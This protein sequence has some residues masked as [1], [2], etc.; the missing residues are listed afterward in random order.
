MKS[1]PTRNLMLSLVAVVLISLVPSVEAACTLSKCMEC[2]M[3]DGTEICQKC[4][5]GYFRD[6]AEAPQQCIQFGTGPVPLESEVGKGIDAERNLI[7][8]CATTGCTDCRA[9]FNVCEACDST[10]HYFRILEGASTCVALEADPESEEEIYPV[11]PDG[12]VCFSYSAN[13]DQILIY[14]FKRMRKLENLKMSFVPYLGDG[15]VC[16]TCDTMPFKIEATSEAG[17]E[18]AATLPFQASFAF[19][20]LAIKSFYED[21]PAVPGQSPVFDKEKVY[22]AE[23]EDTFYKTHT[24]EV[25]SWWLKIW[26]FVTMTALVLVFPM[27]S[28][29]INQFFSFIGY[30]R[31]LDG[32]KSTPTAITIYYLSSNFIFPFWITNPYLSSTADPGCVP[33]VNYTNNGLGCNIAYNF[34]QNFNIMLAAFALNLCVHIYFAVQRGTFY[35]LTEDADKDTNWFLIRIRQYCGLRYFYQFMDAYN[36][37]LLGLAFLNLWQ[38]NGKGS[39][40]GAFIFCVLLLSYYGLFYCFVFAFIRR[41]KKEIAARTKRKVRNAIEYMDE[42]D[43]VYSSDLAFLL[44]RYHV[45]Q[46][47]GYVHWLP[48]L[49][50]FK[51]VIVQIL[52]ASLAGHGQGQLV[53]ILIVEAVWYLLSVVPWGK[54]HI[55][56]N[57]YDLAF[58]LFHI[59]FLILKCISSTNSEKNMGETYARGLAVA[60]STFLLLIGLSCL[61]HSV[62]LAINDL[63]YICYGKTR[64]RAQRRLMAKGAKYAEE[65][66]EYEKA[67]MKKTIISN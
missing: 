42:L 27:S 24:S 48:F 30:V 36:Y 65:E 2:P 8:A 47:F 29:F 55:H 17:D 13:K 46:L 1:I 58:A 49:G 19:K 3:V 59:V 57:I 26:N 38:V 53:P 63:L 52:V 12:D 33:E 7:V 62:F 21:K 14:F 45:H 6:S 40:W 56:D 4:E 41:A 44:E 15:R 20:K 39:S 54:K 37:E 5:A 9:D 35:K 22:T 34:G 18:Y 10:T 67:D 60:L 64:T 51:N 66:E 50:F 43:T 16:E 31:V 32:P 28:Y 61:I 23:V 11:Y 25:I